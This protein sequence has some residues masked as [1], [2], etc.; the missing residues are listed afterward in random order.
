[1]PGVYPQHAH[2]YVHSI[3]SKKP[4]HGMLAAIWETKCTVM[5]CRV[6]SCGRTSTSGRPQGCGR[7][8]EAERP[9]HGVPAPGLPDHRG[10]ARLSAGGAPRTS[11]PAG[12]SQPLAPWMFFVT[13]V[14]ASLDQILIYRVLR[15]DT[16]WRL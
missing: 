16:A 6:C 9:L 10:V 7:P 8:E 14:L 15:S 11:R 3:F 1:M 12:L 13:F 2:A 4:L 5:P